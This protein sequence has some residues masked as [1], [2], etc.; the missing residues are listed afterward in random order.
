M[1]KLQ[2]WYVLLLFCKTKCVK[3]LISRN[4]MKNNNIFQ[5]AV[6]RQNVSAIKHLVS[7]EV[8]LA[9]KDSKL[10]NVF[11]FAATTNKELIE[12]MYIFFSSFYKDCFSVENN[13]I[14]F[15]LDVGRESKLIKGTKR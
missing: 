1:A 2:S 4:L 12:V 14:C 7:K 13:Y 9:R 15:Y 5:I 6:K 3:L 10:N 8:D 11:H